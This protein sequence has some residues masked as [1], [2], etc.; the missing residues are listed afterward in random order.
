MDYVSAVDSNLLCPIC[1]SAFY[2]PTRLLCDH[3]FCKDCLQQSFDNR[4]SVA[5]TCPSCR[6][7]VDTEKEWTLPVQRIITRMLDELVVTCPNEGCEDEK[8][9][10]EIRAHLD[11]YCQYT[12]VPCTGVTCEEFIPRKDANGECL[13]G[14]VTCQDCGKEMM[15]KD[16]EVCVAHLSCRNTTNCNIESRAQPM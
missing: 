13:H 10:G 15:A 7:V 14:L 9:R 4:R 1:H 12:P 3:V 5:K 11:S 16:I 2:E 6:T 8:C